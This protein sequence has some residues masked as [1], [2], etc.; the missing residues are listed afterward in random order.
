MN[1]LGGGGG[2][3]YFLVNVVPE[4]SLGLLGS[5]DTLLHNSGAFFWGGGGVEG[6]NMTVIVTVSESIRF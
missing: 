6:R 1:D 3:E 4:C 2:G 5:F